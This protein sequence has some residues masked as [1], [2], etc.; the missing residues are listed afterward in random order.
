MDVSH[1]VESLLEIRFHDHVHQEATEELC[2]EIEV[3]FCR[4]HNNLIIFVSH[5]IGLGPKVDTNN[6]GLDQRHKHAHLRQILLSGELNVRVQHHYYRVGIHVEGWALKIDGLAVTV[7]NAT[8]DSV[9]LLDRV[10][11]D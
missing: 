9:V 3:H 7:L 10:D 5:F 8:K 4:F 2:A 11:G 1:Q 6:E